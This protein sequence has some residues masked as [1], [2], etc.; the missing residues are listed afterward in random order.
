MLS[1]I[2]AV[3][4]ICNANVELGISKQLLACD[5]GSAYLCVGDISAV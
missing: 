2:S 1:V 3:D 5:L 4:G